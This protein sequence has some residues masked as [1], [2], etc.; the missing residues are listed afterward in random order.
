MLGLRVGEHLIPVAVSFPDGELDPRS[1]AHGL[2]NDP[3]QERPDLRATEPELV[4][5]HALGHYAESAVRLARQD[6]CGEG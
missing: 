4:E 1:L 2:R 6:V 5:R 3:P